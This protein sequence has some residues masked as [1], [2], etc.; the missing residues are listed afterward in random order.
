M[1]ILGERAT[2]FF[3]KL[4]ATILPNIGMKAYIILTK[5]ARGSKGKKVSADSASQEIF[6][7]LIENLLQLYNMS[8]KKGVLLC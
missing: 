7:S 1:Q 5:S 2:T 4:W 8:H 3:A 6:E